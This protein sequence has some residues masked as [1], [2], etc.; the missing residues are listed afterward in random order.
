[1]KT[2]GIIAAVL[3]SLLALVMGLDKYEV[4]PVSEAVMSVAEMAIAFLTGLVLKSP[5]PELSKVSLK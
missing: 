1:M 5:V 2:R 3:G 4:I